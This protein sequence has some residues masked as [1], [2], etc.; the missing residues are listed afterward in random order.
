MKASEVSAAKLDP[1][2][3]PTTSPLAEP[4]M[5]SPILSRKWANFLTRDLLA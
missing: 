4:A 2:W 3:A 5:A 1:P